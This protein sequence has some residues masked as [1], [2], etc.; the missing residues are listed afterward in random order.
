MH[1]IAL[2]LFV[3]LTG[4]L[5]VQAQIIK[6][7]TTW[8]FSAK[9]INGDQYELTIDCK[10]KPEWHLWSIDP[11]GD[12]LLIP[13]SFTFDKNKLAVPTGKL[14]EKGKRIDKEFPGTDGITHFYENRVTYTQAFKVTGNTTIKGN[15]HYQSCDHTQCLKPEDKAF[16]V[17]ITDAAADTA[18]KENVTVVD[19]LTKDS[20]KAQ[21]TVPVATPSS[22][23]TTTETTATT[24]DSMKQSGESSNLYLLISGLGYGLISVFTPCVFA[25][26]PMTVSFFLKRS[27]D[28]KTGIK[29]ALL[30][31]LSIILIFTILGALISF[32]LGG[33]ALN[34]IA[35]NWIVNLFFFAIF[36]IF[37]ISFL[38]AFEITLPSSWS[39]ATD[40]NANTNSFLGI[41]FMA[42]TL[43]I[44]SFSC[45][46]PFI[47]NLVVS[48][49]NGGKM[50]AFFGFFG[51]SLGMA[52]PF[53]LFALFP[54]WLNKLSQQGGWLNAVKV[55]FGIVEIAL[56]LKFLS[57]ADLAN[58]WRLL[59]REIFIAIWMVLSLVLGFYLLGIIRFSHDTEL[60]KNDWGLPYL[61][62]PRLFFAI[63][64]LSFAV[65]LMPG[66]WGAP[67]K[68]MS[69][70]L[71]P[72][73]TQ[74]FVM[75]S[76]S[77]GGGGEAHAAPQH[78]YADKLHI[79]EPEIS[80][81]YGLETYYDY[82]EA[83][84]AS[85]KAKKPIFL[86]FTGINCVNCRKMEA[87]VWSDPEVMKRMKENFIVASLFSDV[88]N[89]ALP[90][91]EQYQSAYLGAKVTT[92]G[93]RNE[94]LQATK[95]N[96]N[97]QP[98]YFFIDEDEKQLA[99]KG[100]GYEPDPAKFVIHLDKVLARYKELHP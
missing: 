57:N 31:S 80:K 60:P 16:S 22:P 28:R 55:T 39:T 25:M 71:P 18:A 21:T 85:K 72:M 42:M 82:N 19:T 81:K 46:G 26:L 95:F 2:L 30:Y 24:T 79:Y 87:Q 23:A 63:S 94:D 89:I 37:G 74:D 13:P 47:G 93:D 75:G 1:K 58:G 68:G 43:V 29:N 53:S 64:A 14:K 5:Q 52:L 8:T 51:F 67:L 34:G 11:G 66:L 44:V 38:G 70:M 73:G 6:D 15:V 41:F 88:D 96:S 56:A 61:S 76:G 50:A 3:L 48:I 7:P 35:T 100:Y 27:K 17:E 40:K 97:S 77:G 49:S 90:E 20:A 33:N 54:S 84:A 83:L 65:Y 59:D 92:L 91:A 32:T 12:G 4:A 45:T 69:A 36:M 78:K 98:F 10:L 99:D 9:K 62:I 86:D